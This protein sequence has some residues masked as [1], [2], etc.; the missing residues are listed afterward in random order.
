MR[1]A[2]AVLPAVLMVIPMH[3]APAQATP[4]V[5]L[6]APAPRGAMSV[7]EALRARRSVRT[8]QDE[9][10][11][12]AQL[13]Q[14]LWA[15]QGI[16]DAE[17]HRTAPSAG[18]RYPLEIYVVAANVTG[19]PAGVYKYRPTEH[20]L[21]RHVEGDQRPHLVQAAVQQ[22]W[23]LQ[24]PVVLA[25]TSVDERTRARY[26][27]RTDRYVAIETGHVGQSV[28]L[29]A[30]A[31]GLGTTVVGAFLDDSVSAVLRLERTERP[32]V[33]LPVGRPR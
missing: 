6:P 5:S 11:S 24:A 16:T 2:L 4:T 27:D 18:A 9:P 12:L 10:L 8:L 15:A 30:A 17:G 25:I 28:C 14:L 1:Y 7:E 20:D 26:R 13:G 29:Q 22:E 32:I 19:L 23:I 31:L 33:L 21:V 3:S